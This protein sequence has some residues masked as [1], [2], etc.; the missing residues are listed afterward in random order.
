M[1]QKQKTALRIA[2]LGHKRIPSREGGIEIVVK[3]LATR[4]VELGHSVTCFNRRGHHVSGEEFDKG[5]QKEFRGIRMKYVLTIDKKG[6][7]AI[8]SSFFASLR[9]AF[10]R[11]D[12][13]HY[14]AEGPCFWMWIPKLFG[15]R[16]VATIHG[17]DHRR[18]K[19]GKLAK[20]VIMRGEKCAVRRAD[21]IIVLT[22]AEQDY[23][24][25]VYKRDTRL[26]PNGANH[27]V[28][29]PANEMTTTWGLHEGEYFLFFGRIVP[30]KGLRYLV[31]AYQ[32][33]K[34]DKP[35]IIAGGS[36][37]TQAF[38][39][40]LKEMAKGD[41]R[42]RFVGF[43]EG[44]LRKELL[45][46]AYVYVLPSDLEGMPLSLL[47]AMSY[48][49]CCL[50]SDIPA[51]TEVVED[52]AVTFP[53]GDVE[54]LAERMQYLCDNPTLVEEYGRLAA[55][56]IESKYNWDSVVEQTLALYQGDKA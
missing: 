30:E 25:E 12:V 26:I 1:K 14:H 36:S 38:M 4:M 52:H 17:L 34:T 55:P 24:R 49:N 2:M 43:V 7:A 8:T 9:A 6:L 11:Y 27:S 10:G 39:D 41:P 20:W 56:F 23:F 47:E 32:R 13:V 31:E 45:S 18:A 37:D 16:C 44:A 33:V 40:E 21:E 28:K 15:K 48:G 53:R 19:W 3:E 29:C 46:G 35:L 42:I 54:A 51:C 50:T 22:R 5:H